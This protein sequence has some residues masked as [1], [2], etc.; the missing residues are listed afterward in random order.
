MLKKSLLP[1]MLF[2]ACAFLFAACS[3]TNTNTNTTANANSN[4]AVTTTTTTST[5]TASPAASN[6]ASTNTAT[7]TTNTTAVSTT[8]GEKIGVP[9]CDEYIAKYEACI[10]GKVPE[11]ARAQYNSG[12]AQMRKSWQTLAANPQT[13]ASLAQA[14]KTAS[15]SARQSFKSF[16][17]DF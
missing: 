1:L 2:V 4:K 14:C 9:E 12:L 17:C 16:G 5:T 8:T 11:A 3:T 6:T 15:E 7:T 13:K 10:S